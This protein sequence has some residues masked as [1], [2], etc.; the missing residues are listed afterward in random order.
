[1]AE[2][3][4]RAG[5]D[6]PMSF[7]GLRHTWASLAVMAGTPLFVVARALGH[8]NTKMVEKHSAT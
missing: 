8:T 7:H 3:C 5:I 4:K 1:M 2:A 6:P